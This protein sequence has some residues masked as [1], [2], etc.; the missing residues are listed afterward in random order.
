MHR[1]FPCCGR[2]CWPP[3]QRSSGILGSN[4]KFDPTKPG[5]DSGFNPLWNPLDDVAGNSLFSWD[6][7]ADDDGIPDSNWLDLGFPAQSTPD[8]RVYKPLF[9]IHCVD[10]DGRLNVNTHGN[11]AQVSPTYSNVT[12]VSIPNVFFAG[13]QSA[14]NNNVTPT[15]LRRSAIPGRPGDAPARARLRAG[16]GESGSLFNNVASPADAANY[17]FC[18]RGTPTLCSRADLGDKP[19]PTPAFAG[20]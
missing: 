16:G 3:S 14:S 18:L 15:S 9:A 1:N 13:S 17:Q 19:R 2:S 12:N 20:T 8:G 10:L 5:Y 11:I 6:A 7:D 4:P